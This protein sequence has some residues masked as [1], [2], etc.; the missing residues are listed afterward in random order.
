MEAPFLKAGNPRLC[1]QYNN[2]ET[3]ENIGPTLS[4]TSTWLLLCLFTCF[5]VNF[6]SDCLTI[7]PILRENETKIE[8]TVKSGKADYHIIINKEVGFKRAGSNTSI[9]CDGVKVDSLSLPI[10]SDGEVHEVVVN[11]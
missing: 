4:G 8:L 3:G 9:S 11:I 1:T 7:E 10:F 5:G 2:C 6:T